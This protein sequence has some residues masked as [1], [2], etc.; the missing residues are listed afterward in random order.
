MVTDASDRMLKGRGLALMG[1]GER[2]MIGG[3]DNDLSP[4]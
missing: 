3:I 2:T 1:S 4:P